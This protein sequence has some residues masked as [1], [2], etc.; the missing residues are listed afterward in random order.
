MVFTLFHLGPALLLG[1]LLYRYL[2]FPT[3]LVASMVV[4][5]RT[6]FVY[7]GLVDGSLH[8]WLHSFAGATFLGFMLIG[9]I[10]MLRPWIEEMMQKYLNISQSPNDGSMV[11]AAFIGVY[12]HVLIDSIL[13]S[14]M[15][16]FWPYDPR[17]LLGVFTTKE[18]Y[19]FCV[20]S[21][22]AGLL[23][24]WLYSAGLYHKISE[25]PRKYV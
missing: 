16:P 24:Y 14:D 2:D 11:G 7:I 19:L 21:F 25:L 5:I 22:A 20:A 23:L 1:M 18:V 4:D 13:Y 12:T 15:R 9:T 3:I 6:L 17:P 10:T 8:G